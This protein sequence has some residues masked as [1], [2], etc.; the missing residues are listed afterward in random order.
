MMRPIRHVTIRSL[1]FLMVLWSVLAKTY[2]CYVGDGLG[3][4][5]CTFVAFLHAVIWTFPVCLALFISDYFTIYLIC[6]LVY[7][8]PVALLALA[9]QSH[10]SYWIMLPLL[11]LVN[12]LGNPAAYVCDVCGVTL[13]GGMGIIIYVLNCLPYALLGP[14]F[15]LTCPLRKRI[16]LP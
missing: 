16:D 8:S 13:D 2:V 7:F 14:V 6:F 12:S 3:P 10:P 9:S 5:L 15:S 1:L 11:A 4:E